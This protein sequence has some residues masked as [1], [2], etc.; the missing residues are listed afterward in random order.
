MAQR[1]TLIWVGGPFFLLAVVLFVIECLEGGSRD[2]VVAMGYPCGLLG[3]LGASMYFAGVRAVRRWIWIS[4]NGQ[5]AEATVVGVRMARFQPAIGKTIYVRTP[6]FPT[7]VI[8]YSY[9]DQ[10]GNMYDGHS[11]F[12]SVAGAMPKPGDHG[13]ARFDPQHPAKSIWIREQ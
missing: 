2:S 7:C 3:L 13:L 8:D 11:R 12:L 1:S 6:A 4:E 9:R 10:L 5:S